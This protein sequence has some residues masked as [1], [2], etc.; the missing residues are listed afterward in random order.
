[1]KKCPR[2]QRI[3]DLK[4]AYLNFEFIVK[5][6]KSGKKLEAQDTPAVIQQ[7]EKALGK[8]EAEIRRMEQKAKPTP[9]LRR[10]KHTGH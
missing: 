8:L 9:P 5:L 4:S 3:H 2:N 1:M 7:L 6:M 10:K